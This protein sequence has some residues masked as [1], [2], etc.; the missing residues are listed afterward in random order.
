L[1]GYPIKLVN[2]TKIESVTHQITQTQTLKKG[3]CSRCLNA[4]VARVFIRKMHFALVFL[5][6]RLF[7]L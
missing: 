4:Y 6:L 7:F 2:K 3:C 1:R 5:V